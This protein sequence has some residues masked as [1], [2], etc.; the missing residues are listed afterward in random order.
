MIELITEDNIAKR[1][2]KYSRQQMIE[3][4]QELEKEKGKIPEEKDL[5]NNPKYPSFGTYINEFVTWN[6][7][8]IEAGFEPNKRGYDAYHTKETCIKDI[9][10]WTN[11]HNGIPPISTDFNDNPKYPSR[12]TIQKLFGTWNNAIIAAGFKP[13]KLETTAKGRKGE[14]QTLSEFRTEGVIDLSGKNNKSSC[15]GICPKGGK[16]DTKS[17]SPRKKH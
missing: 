17:S 15:D 9:Q 16:F 12:S 13:N 1:T 7:A 5:V 8:L 3:K 10:Q 14:I 2:K 6:N 4:L 11:K